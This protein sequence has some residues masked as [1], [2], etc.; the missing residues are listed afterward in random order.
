MSGPERRPCEMPSLSLVLKN[1]N[2]PE[3]KL[4][5]AAFFGEPSRIP[6]GWTQCTQH[7]EVLGMRSARRLVCDPEPTHAFAQV[8]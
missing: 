4:H 6:R 2:I 8:C 5:R 3:H 7:S 1:E